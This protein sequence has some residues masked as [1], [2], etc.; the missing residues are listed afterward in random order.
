VRDRVVQTALKLVL[1]P[2]WE[3]R[4]AEQ[5]YGFRPGR[6]AKD[7]LRQVQKELRGGATWV[8]DVDGDE[9]AGRFFDTIPHEVLH[10]VLHEALVERIERRVAGGRILELIQSF[11]K[12]GVMGEGQHWEPEAGTP[13]GAVISPLLANLYLDDL[14]QLM[15]SRGWMMVRYADDMVVLCRSKAEA[16]EALEM[17]RGWTE[18]HGLRLHAEKTRVLDATER[19]GFDF[20]GYHVERGMRWPSERSEARLRTAIRARTRRRTSGP[21]GEIIAGINPIVRGWFAYFKHGQ[22]NVFRVLDGWIRMRLRSILR[23]RTKRKGRGDGLDHLRWPNAYFVGHAL[24]TMV[25]A[26]EAA[27]HSRGG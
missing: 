9:K 13:R 10:E 20:L 17:L 25:T 19:G 11:L 3:A 26:R 2:I 22:G 7:A 6:N 14:D 16:M 12:Q 8:V 1:E 21:L 15:A 24:F 4:F 18:G 27:V 5:S 23:A